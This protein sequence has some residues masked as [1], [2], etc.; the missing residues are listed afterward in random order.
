MA[1]QYAAGEVNQQDI[2]IVHLRQKFS[3]E[4]GFEPG[5]SAICVGALT[6]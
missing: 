3:H 1:V 2:Y 6:K 4:P 5:S